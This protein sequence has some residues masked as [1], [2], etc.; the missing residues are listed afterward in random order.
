MGKGIFPEERDIL[1]AKMLNYEQNLTI[2]APEKS[3]GALAPN[4][5]AFAR[6]RL[7]FEPDVK[8]RAILES[9][10]RRLILLCSR[11]WGKSTI[12]AI[13]AVHRAYTQPESLVVVASPSE[14]QSAEWLRKAEKFV[15]KLGISVKGDGDNA[16]S[17]KLPNGSRI[18]GLP[19]NEATV[20]GFSAVNLLMIDEA[21]RV[22]DELYWALRPMLATS[23]GDLW[24]MSTPFGQRG[25]FWE[26][27]SE[28]GAEWMRVEGPATDC[29]RIPEEYLAEE[30]RKM[31]AALFEQEF[32]CRFTDTGE[33]MFPAELVDGSVAE[34]ELLRL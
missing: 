24:L 1:R 17:V 23:G 19:G 3:A 5:V 9:T 14:R 2:P 10:S 6:S 18:V 13:K 31:T 33:G 22:K 7:G 30:R 21:S 28:G 29:A 25:L 8:Q 20:R 26:E 16:Q 32:L 34:H 27:W 15:R 12:A 4:A 11:Q